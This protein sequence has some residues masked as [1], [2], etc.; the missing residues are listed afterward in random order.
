[1]PRLYYY[2]EDLQ[3]LQ[4]YGNPAVDH[5]ALYNRAVPECHPASAISLDDPDH[6]DVESMIET[7]N[8]TLL[9]KADIIP[10]REGFDPWYLPNDKGLGPDGEYFQR[11]QD[12][13]LS[14]TTQVGQFADVINADPVT[15]APA[16]SEWE[17][18]EI[19]QGFG[20]LL[21]DELIRVFNF[22]TTK[23][24]NITSSG[25]VDIDG[26]KTGADSHI[27]GTDRAPGADKLEYY[28]NDGIRYVLFDENGWHP[29][30]I[31]QY[32]TWLASEMGGHFQ[33]ISGT[34]DDSWVGIGTG[35]ALAWRPNGYPA[36]TTPHDTIFP[37]VDLSDIIVTTGL[38]NKYLGNDGVY[39]SFPP[40]FTTDSPAGANTL[41][42]TAGTESNIV[43]GHE[44]NDGYVWVD[45]LTGQ[46][47]VLGWEDIKTDLVQNTTNIN[48]NA[49]DINNI[50]IAMGTTTEELEIINQNISA[51]Q[52][53]T[54]LMTNTRTGL[55]RPDGTTITADG[56]GVFSVVAESM[57]DIRLLQNSWA[58][59][60]FSPPVTLNYSTT[61][62]IDFRLGNNFQ[63]LTTGNVTFGIG[64]IDN[65]GQTGII[66]IQHM[67]AN[68]TITF[69]T[70]Y[71]F[72]G[73]LR[74]EASKTTGS[75]D[76][77]SYYIL[78]NASVVI[79]PLMGLNG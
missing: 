42:L 74:P 24:L 47:H 11:K 46:M 67:G 33:Y 45:D 62:N 9:T 71:Y 32:N 14:V 50:V 26:I 34:V 65:I 77:L 52:N 41:G 39:H 73:G 17:V 20:E 51:L 31:T 78:G 61:M 8:A 37:S 72:P 66:V 21:G 6:P 56:N 43:D 48:K 79:M 69:G 22:D 44:L 70:G 16:N 53:A 3:Q 68:Q 10:A 5:Q 63:I 76:M 49:Q 29:D 15:G 38:G 7:I 4:P 12:L 30:I 40:D 27:I 25:H 2:D 1:M 75:T 58:K 23:P 13:P 54:L 35:N 28:N 19:N 18:I 55:G 60:Q 36:G 59:P 57:P 64:N